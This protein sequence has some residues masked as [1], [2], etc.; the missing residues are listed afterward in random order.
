MK[1]TDE[2]SFRLSQQDF[3]N[4]NWQATQAI[5]EITDKFTDKR[6]VEILLTSFGVSQEA[7]KYYDEPCS[8]IYANSTVYFQFDDAGKFMCMGAYE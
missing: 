3:S 5:L 6:K 4:A 1:D 8:Y 7:S 2:G